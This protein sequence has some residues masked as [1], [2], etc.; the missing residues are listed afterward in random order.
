MVAV[1]PAGGGGVAGAGVSKGRLD[2]VSAGFLITF[3]ERK[4]ENVVRAAHDHDLML[5]HQGDKLLAVHECHGDGVRTGGF[6]LG[7]LA[8][9]AGGDDDDVDF[10]IGGNRKKGRRRDMKPM[11][12]GSCEFPPRRVFSNGYRGEKLLA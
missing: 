8:E 5:D 7:A 2:S 9:V 12:I 4:I 6:V 1:L 10:M 11:V 3:R